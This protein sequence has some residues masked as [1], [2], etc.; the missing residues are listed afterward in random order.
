[1]ARKQ[2]TRA[3]RIVSLCLWGLILAVG[4]IDVTHAGH[5]VRFLSLLQIA[6]A[7]MALLREIQ[8]LMEE[9]S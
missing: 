2:I 9:P 8:G 5:S 6:V 7:L 1:M 3:N 4:V